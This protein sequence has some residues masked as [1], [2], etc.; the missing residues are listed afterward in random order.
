MANKKYLQQLDKILEENTLL[1]TG[2]LPQEL[3][4]VT[5][6]IGQ[7]P[8]QALIFISFV[9][10]AVLFLLFPLEFLKTIRLILLISK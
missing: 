3:A 9:I 2:G 8:W 4:P 7:R 6:L 10:T 1:T 5:S